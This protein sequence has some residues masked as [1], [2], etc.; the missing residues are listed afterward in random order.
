MVYDV[1]ILTCRN[2]RDIKTVTTKLL[3][4]IEQTFPIFNKSVICV[5]T[6]IKKRVACHNP[7]A[8]FYI[9]TFAEK[10]DHIGVTQQHLHHILA[11]LHAA[12]YEYVVE[13]KWVTK[14]TPSAKRRKKNISHKRYEVS[15]FLPRI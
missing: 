4:H 13:S 11:V 5:T 12:A 2:N 8:S 3:Y 1:P 9:T 14:V 7:F 15:S 6:P 10:D